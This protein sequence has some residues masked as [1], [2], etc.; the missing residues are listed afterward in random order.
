MY[1]FNSKLWATTQH[2]P[3]VFAI[4]NEY[5]EQCLKRYFLKD[6]YNQLG[7]VKRLC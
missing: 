6:K 7:M 1:E 4:K 2:K 3:T 5:V